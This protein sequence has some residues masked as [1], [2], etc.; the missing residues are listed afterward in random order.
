MRGEIKGG[1]CSQADVMPSILDYLNCPDARMSFGRSIFSKEAPPQYA[2]QY[3]DNLFQIE[4][5]NYILLFDGRYTTGIFDKINDKMLKNNLI[6]QGL[7]DMN[8]METALKAII[9]QHHQA[10][11][12]NALVPK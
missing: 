3:E 1:I 5:K 10:M 7:P 12:N 9:Q 8:R 4:D 2:V 11:V 6:M